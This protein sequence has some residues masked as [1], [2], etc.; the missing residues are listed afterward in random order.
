MI[1]DWTNKRI[2][3]LI[4]SHGILIGVGCIIALIAIGNLRSVINNYVHARKI[5]EI[6]SCSTKA[7][8]NGQNIMI[9]ER[10]WRVDDVSSY[11]FVGRPDKATI[12]LIEVVE[13]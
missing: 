13:E 4:Y 5:S 1:K 2:V 3:E 11:D 9:G 12:E 7:F 10:T 8:T 6:V